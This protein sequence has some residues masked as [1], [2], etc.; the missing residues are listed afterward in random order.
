VPLVPEVSGVLLR[1]LADVVTQ[2]GIPSIYLF[3]QQE[4]PLT[5]CEPTAVRV[6]LPAYR[7]LLARAIEL[8]GDPA[9]G[10][11]CALQ[12]REAAF[13][14]MGPLVAHALTLRRAIEEADQF[15]A[16]LFEG[17]HFHLTERAGTARVRCEFPRAHDP[18]DRTLAEFMTAGLMRL[19]RG[20]GCTQ[21]HFHGARFEYGRP[22]Y[23]PA[24]AKVFDD[25][26]AFSQ[27]YTGVEFAAELL[28]RP[29]SYANP[30]LQTLVHAQAEQRL[31]GLSRPLGFTDRLRMYLLS[32]PAAR[33]PSME[34]AARG[35]GVSVRT[36]R[37]RL[38]ETGNTYRDITQAMQGERARTLL[39]K[40][41]RSVQSVADALGFSNIDAFHR[42]FKRWTGRTACKY[43]VQPL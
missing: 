33:V 30:V 22:Y 19:L 26:Q 17:A 10:L 40:D 18:T 2:A 15:Q 3:Q 27:T 8:T 37:R 20:L 4:R 24:Y 11:R 14:V 36:L 5:A 39:R 13:D 12:P 43:R 35:L 25:K 23:A 6:P 28:D 7:A 31:Q 32:Q 41:D 1:V 29:Q 21:E 42:A 16:L 38:S 9:L 34:A